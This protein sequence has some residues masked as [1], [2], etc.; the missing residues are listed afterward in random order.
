MPLRSTLWCIVTLA[1]ALPLPALTRELTFADRVA[2]QRAIDRVYHS[3]QVGLTTPFEQAVPQPVLEAKVE[4]YLRLSAALERYWNTPVTSEMLRAEMERQARE[5]RM[6]NRLREIH[7]ALGDDSFL[8]QECLV[9]PALV[10]RLTRKLYAYDPHFS[11]AAREEAE[12]L[13]PDLDSLPTRSWDEWW[14]T[15]EREL[16]AGSVRAVAASGP[17][18]RPG[19]GDHPESRLDGTPPCWPDDTWDNGSLD[20]YP[21]PRSDHTAV[22]TG[23]KM[24]V[25]GGTGGGPL[26]SGARYDPATDTWT[27]TSLVNAPSPRTTHTAIWT[28]SEMIVWG[29]IAGSTTLNSGGRYDPV[30]DSWTALSL[31][32]APA[33][34]FNHTA[35]W[36]GSEMLV[37]GGRVTVSLSVDTGGRY[38]PDTDTW[39]ATSTAGAPKERAFHTAAWTGDEMV[40]W[41]GTKG[42]ELLR[43]G[44]RYD[45][46]SDVWSPTTLNG[47]PSARY[48]H[49]AVWTGNKMIVWGGFV[50]GSITR[51]GGRYDPTLDSW[52]PTEIKT[53]P[54][55]RTGH[56]AIWTGS[57]M[58]VFGG[59]G[60]PGGP[61]VPPLAT[62]GVYD[63]STN[64]WLPTSI[65]GAPARR[66]HSVV[67]T[68]SLMVIWGGSEG[69][70]GE[71]SGGRYDPTADAWTPTSV[72]SAPEGRRQH[73]A[74]WTGSW[75]LIWGGSDYSYVNTGGRYDP[76]L[77]HWSP[78]SRVGAPAPRLGHTSVWTGSR[79]VVWGGYDHT[80]RGDGGRYD[81]LTNSWS[82]ISAVGAPASRAYHNAVWTGTEMIV[83]G[84]SGA[85][86]VALGDGARYDPASD[87]WAPVS[88]VG[89]PAPRSWHAG[90][91]TG[92]EM[93]VFGGDDWSAVLGSG[94]RYDPAADT[95]AP[96]T[97][98]GAPGPRAEPLAVWTGSE[99]IVWGGYADDTELFSG[100][101][102]DPEGDTWAAVTLAGA[103]EASYG[104]S[105]VWTGTG[106]VVWGGYDITNTSSVVN[107]GA[108]YD[109]GTDVWTRTSAAGA[110]TGRYRHVAVWTA[111]H[112]FVWGGDNGTFPTSGGRYALGH[113]VD[114]D[115]DGYSECTGDC[116]DDDLAVNP[117]ATEICDGLDND[118]DGVAAG[119]VDLDGDGACAF[120]ECDDSDSTV[121]Q[122]P[123]EVQFVEID[124]P[125]TVIGFASQDDIAGVSTV[126]QV[127]AGRLSDLRSTGDFARS[128]CVGS[129]PDSPA[130]DPGED[131]FPGDGHYYLL[132]AENPCGTGSYGNESDGAEREL[133]ACP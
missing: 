27:A 108:R 40:V 28:G 101:R 20:D 42:S 57:R 123:L 89:A 82:V 26:D 71:A 54:Q 104:A 130:Q 66:Q 106:M 67:W 105:A 121:Q 103:P 45:P 32:E 125:P 110:P 86:S 64:D 122:N 132:R 23:T 84:G 46:A 72:Q 49:S 87:V 33:P 24:I 53:A 94:G 68:D 92:D 22:W 124:D 13:R 83:W 69:P 50:P 96:T 43:S 58:I 95:W 21:E 12:G 98:V 117:A 5:T 18:P 7:A 120:E 78:T 29:G 38:D 77:D 41:G 1:V 74:E 37:W 100:G 19:L 60:T 129:F 75:V 63:P 81:P 113:S 34:R 16:D 17:L 61:Q 31:A 39:S 131:P 107:T 97:L 90:V 62:G 4:R 56:T 15:V 55:A 128:W 35:I 52:I 11:S 59:D 126:Y 85:D 91:W 93:I 119:E 80:Y 44:G 79:M 65:V 111:S 47:A 112:M 88:N 99:M 9:R 70:A 133:D 48:G 36:T 76:A 8:I 115:G 30:T 116:N 114:D 6:P 10:E 25:W 102:Y 127:A 118:C 109:P 73:T 2:A 14:L 51:S 3:H